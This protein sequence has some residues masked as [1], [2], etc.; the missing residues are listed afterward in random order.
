MWYWGLCTPALQFCNTSIMICSTQPPDKLMSDALCC[1]VSLQSWMSS[2]THAMLFSVVGEIHGPLCH[3]SHTRHTT[4]AGDWYRLLTLSVPTVSVYNSLDFQEIPAVQMGHH[5]QL[6][7]LCSF[8]A[9]LESFHISSSASGI[10]G[11]EN[12]LLFTSYLMITVYSKAKTVDCSD[13]FLSFI[14]WSVHNTSV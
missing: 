9:C 14:V 2:L 3:P 11:L 4:Q 5:I 10:I 1:K 7:Q 13:V 8:W 6:P 12:F